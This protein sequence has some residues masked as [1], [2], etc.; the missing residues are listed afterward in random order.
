MYSLLAISA[1]ATYAGGSAADCSFHQLQASNG[2]FILRQQLEAGQ[3]ADIRQF[4]YARTST[5]SIQC[6]ISVQPVGTPFALLDPILAQIAEDCEVA[7][8]TEGDRNFTAQV[9][10]AISESFSK[11][12]ERMDKFWELLEHE[13]SVRFQRISASSLVMPKQIVFFLLYPIRVDSC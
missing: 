11:E 3:T 6:K 7:A 10:S 13:H 2:I 9:A 8:P 1:L 4:N 12:G 5:V